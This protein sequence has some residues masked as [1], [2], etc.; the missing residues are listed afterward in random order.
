MGPTQ[1]PSQGIQAIFSGNI[2][3]WGESDRYCSLVFR[4]DRIV[5]VPSFLRIIQALADSVK[6][7]IPEVELTFFAVAV[8]RIAYC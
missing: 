4:L 6:S 8:Y 5:L 2:T 1:T 7:L 3:V